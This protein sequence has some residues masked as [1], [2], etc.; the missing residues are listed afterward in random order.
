MNRAFA[1]KDP[2]PLCVLQLG[3]RYSP[4]RN[5]PRER[6]RVQGECATREYIRAYDV[7]RRAPKKRTQE[8][9]RKHQET[10]GRMK[11]FIAAC[12]VYQREVPGAREETEEVIEQLNKR[13]APR[14]EN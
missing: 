8:T 5:G 7:A 6:A 12:E 10:I 2:S 13:K 4:T 11:V 3:L 9:A 1:P 14:A